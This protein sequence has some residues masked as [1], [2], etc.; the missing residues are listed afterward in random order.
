MLSTMTGKTFKQSEFDFFHDEGYLR[1][2]GVHSA[3]RLRAMRDNILRELS[4]LNIWSGGKSVGSA[5]KDLPPFQQ[6]AKLSSMVKIAG[7]D[8]LLNT[9]EIRSA[10]SGLAGQV[11]QAGHG[12]QLLLS[13]PH[14]GRW[15]LAN[16]NWHVDVAAK[17][18]HA[19][20]GIQ[21]FYLIDDVVPHGGATL[22][23]A[24]SHRMTGEMAGRLRGSLKMPADLEAVLSASNTEIIEMSGRAG[25][26]FLMDMRVLHSP[27]INSAKGIR[28]MATTR[29]GLRLSR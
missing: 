9:P 17:P 22:A 8:E 5:L 26:V 27:S 6:I 10:I 24:R 21:A 14:Q 18:G 3:A 29:F 7:L 13:L 11:P 1:L 16:L 15:S 25:D 20:P 23:L 28:M 12:S 19:I 4:R 2:S